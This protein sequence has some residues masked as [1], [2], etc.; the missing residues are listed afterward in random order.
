MS[1]T[2]ATR[3]Q[4]A[5]RPAPGWPAAPLRLSL[6]PTPSAGFTLPADALC[7]VGYGD[8]AR[9]DDPR[10]VGV[11]LSPLHGDAGIEIWHSP[12]PVRAGVDG[13]VRYAENG[14]LLMVQL[15]LADGADADPEAAAD[16]L[17]TQLLAFVAAR[18]YP[19]LL[20]IWNYIEAINEGE[21]DRERY[22]RFCAGRHR[23]LAGLPEF[24]R[25]LPAA[26]AI[27]SHRGGLQLHAFAGRQP[28]LQVENPRQVSA[29][30]YPRSY[31]P[32]SPSFS[33]ATL[34]PW[35]DGA[36]LFVSGTASIVGHATA[37]AGDV[38]AQLLQ[39]HANLE[40]LRAHAAA[41]L[42]PGIAAQQL[43]P[44]AYTVY[45]RDAEQL[46]AVLPVLAARFDDAP[47]KVLLGDICRRELLI[48]VEASYRVDSR[49][50]A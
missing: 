35:A 37:H 25:R 47:Y 23:A 14:E 38:V 21:G 46:P 27:G 30:R 15:A 33:R 24:E 34:A 4:P 32:R 11:P 19:H 7:V 5:P 40:V 26:S 29:F 44:E 17:Y 10:W 2:E 28:G 41:S 13:G 9:S 42:L 48:E 31:G 8:A 3:L 12:L 18:G 16:Q 22:R 36:Q 6:A 1:V 45:L 50:S 43:A 49:T 20:R 39:T